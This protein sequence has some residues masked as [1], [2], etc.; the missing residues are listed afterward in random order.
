MYVIHMYYIHIIYIYIVV[1]IQMYRFKQK[2]TL[3]SRL[4]D[5]I[6]VTMT[7]PY[8]VHHI[9]YT[10]YDYTISHKYPNIEHRILNIKHLK[11]LLKSRIQ[12]KPNSLTKH[13]SPYPPFNTKVF[14]TK[15]NIF[16]LFFHFL[17]NIIKVTSQFK[18]T[19]L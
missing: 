2:L 19:H 16:N 7:T 9:W 12:S 4:Q 13:T 11:Y 17:D 15:L 6:L 1:Y 14:N 18:T 8:M 10:I 5:S 3:V